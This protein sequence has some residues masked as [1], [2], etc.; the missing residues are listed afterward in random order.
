MTRRHGAPFQYRIT[1]LN[2]V[3]SCHEVTGDV[4]QPRR[5][6]APSIAASRPEQTR[7]R[8]LDAAAKLFAERGFESASITAIAA[9]AGVSPETVYARFHNK[10][11]LLGT[12]VRRAARRRPGARARAASPRAVVTATDQRAQLRLF[13]A[14]IVPRPSS[15]SGR[16]S[17][18]SPA[19][20]APIP[21]SPSS[22]YSVC[23]P[24]GVRTWG[25]SSMPS[26]PMGHSE[27]HLT[28]R[29]RRCLRSRARRCIIC[30]PGFGAGRG[31]ATATG[32]PTV[33][34]PYSSKGCGRRDRSCEPEQNM[35]ARQFLPAE[36]IRRDPRPRGSQV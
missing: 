5:Y 17:R 29:S 36:G 28:T 1:V 30:S 27:S 15:A 3:L 32:S 11:T 9:E 18:S 19:M 7:Q 2:T 4:K 20:L 24:S 22:P 31:I 21:N 35:W 23:T 26:R 34:E 10:R 12:L 8:V 13:A 6:W 33:S 25:G 16:S 14:D